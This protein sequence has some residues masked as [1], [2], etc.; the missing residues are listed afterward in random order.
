MASRLEQAMIKLN[1]AVSRLEAM[2]LPSAENGAEN[3]VIK[4]EILEIRGMID[5]AMTALTNSG[6]E[7]SPDGGQT[8]GQQ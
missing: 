4:S 7:S 6:G 1:D 2:P 8:D 3:G 5:Q